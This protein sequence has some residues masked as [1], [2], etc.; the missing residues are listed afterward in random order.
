VPLLLPAPLPQVL[1]LP[2]EPLP[3]PVLLLLP[4][5]LLSLMPEPVLLP[6]CH[7]QPMWKLS[8]QPLII[9]QFFSSFSF[10]PNE[11]FFCAGTAFA[12]SVNL[13]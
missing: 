2:P 9:T 1:L 12:V 10:L 11:Y 5:P 7:M 4:V 8:L 6:N 3:R 13:L